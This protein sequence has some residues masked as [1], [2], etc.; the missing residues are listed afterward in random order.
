MKRVLIVTPNPD[1]KTIIWYYLERMSIG[2]VFCA[3]DGEE[4]LRFLNNPRSRVDI[5][6]ISNEMLGSPAEDV[7]KRAKEFN[8]LIRGVVFTTSLHP[9]KVVEAFCGEA[10]VMRVPFSFADLQAAVL[11]Q[12]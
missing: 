8:P 4:A 11:V 10:A 12:K 2:H 3:A 9:Q 5:A 1:V 6:I 7:W